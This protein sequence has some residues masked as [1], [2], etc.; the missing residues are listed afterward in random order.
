[1]VQLWSNEANTLTSGPLIEHKRERHTF[2]S[3]LYIMMLSERRIS[4]VPFSCV[5]N[6]TCLIKVCTLFFSKD[7]YITT[8]P[9][10]P[11]PEWG[12]LWVKL[13]TQLWY[14]WKLQNNLRL[15]IATRTHV[16]RTCCGCYIYIEAH[17]N[18][19]NKG[20]YVH[21][22]WSPHMSTECIHVGTFIND[23]LINT[24]LNMKVIQH[25]TT[26]M[27]N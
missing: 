14:C 23:A 16:L 5:H 6:R 26:Y 27:F 22:T 21:C 25:S 15:G 24:C 9:V 10:F 13:S 7:P 19:T 12:N 3:A 17:L 2:H 8:Y 20:I 4:C 1:M 11:F 18:I